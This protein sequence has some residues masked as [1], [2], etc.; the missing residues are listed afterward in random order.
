MVRRQ[1][2]ARL[3][4]ALVAVICAG[5]SSFQ[6]EPL[7]PPVVSLRG[8]EPEAMGINKQAFRARLSLF[9]PNTVPLR[10]SSGEVELE[11]AGVHAAKGRTIEPFSV[12][13]G[14]ETEVE[15][16]VTMNLLRDAPTLFRALSGGIAGA[17][18]DY[19]LKGHVTVE[20]RG[21][22]RLPIRS[23]GKLDIPGGRPSTAAPPGA[24]L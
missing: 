20:R 12:A 17:G 13:A 18:L 2:A 11:L 16:R 3:I 14:A 5:C 7:E 21:L 8:L 23:S 24:D 6:A 15:I 22:N 10:V 1:F 4:P 9:N 19:E